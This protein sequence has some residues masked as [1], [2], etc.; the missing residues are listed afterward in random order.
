[1]V[2]DNV[3]GR[4]DEE[5]GVLVSFPQS[6]RSDGQGWG[7][8]AA[9]GFE[10]NALGSMVNSFQLFEREEAVFLIAGD[11]WGFDFGAP[12]YEA[13]QAHDCLLQERARARQA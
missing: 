12:S 8:I 13:V 10:H 9:D 4:H 2:D 5:H 1:M 6:E 11:D 3:I 7:S